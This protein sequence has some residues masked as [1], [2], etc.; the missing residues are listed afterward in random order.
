[1][2]TITHLLYL[3]LDLVLFTSILF[4]LLT[5][6]F[7]KVEESFNMQAINDI[8]TYGTSLS[9]YD[10]FL[11][12]GVVPRTFIGSLY[13][14]ILAYIPTKIINILQL[15]SIYKLFICRIILGFTVWQSIRSVRIVLSKKFHFRVSTFFPLII[16]L[17]FHI[18]FYASRTLP[19]TFAMILSNYAFAAWLNVIK[20]Y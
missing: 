2:N 3:F 18:P 9:S 14:S 19:N 20:F 8:L 4:Y 11:F 10:H 16:T 5:I 12:P 1:M 17:Q 7:T 15:S 6:P 13:I